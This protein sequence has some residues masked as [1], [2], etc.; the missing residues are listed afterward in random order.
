MVLVEEESNF[1]ARMMARLISK[2]RA[3]VPGRGNGSN[4]VPERNLYS[5]VDDIIY[6]LYCLFSII[7]DQYYI[8]ITIRL[9]IYWKKYIKKFNVWW[10]SC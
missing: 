9:F 2:R 4:D 5:I 7:C 10:Q 3:D 8:G 6:L 1:L